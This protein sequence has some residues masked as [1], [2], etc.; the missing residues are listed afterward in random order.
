MPDM[1][2]QTI[3]QNERKYLELTVRSADGFSFSP[4]AASIQIKDKD[5]EI[6]EEYNCLISTNKIYGLV[7]PLTTVT[8]GRYKIIWKLE[9]GNAIYYH[10]TILT[11]IE[12]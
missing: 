12:L 9:S 11:V 4:S 6:T 7:T 3:Y 8:T 1:T 2:S 5:E 10:K